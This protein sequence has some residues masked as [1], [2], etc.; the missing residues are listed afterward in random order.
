MKK[1]AIVATIVAVGIVALSGCGNKKQNL[2]KNNNAVAEITVYEASEENAAETTATVS[3]DRLEQIAKE[4][5]QESRREI[6]KGAEYTAYVDS[7]PDVPDFKK[8]EKTEIL[9][10][11]VA[12]PEYI[13]DT[14]ET[15]YLHFTNDNYLV[16]DGY[17]VRVINKGIESEKL[18]DVKMFKNYNGKLVIVGFS[19]I[20]DCRKSWKILLMDDGTIVSQEM[21][22]YNID[23]VFEEDS[24][25][26][27]LLEAAELT[28]VQDQDAETIE[29][30]RFN[31]VVYTASMP[32]KA[33]GS[34]ATFFLDNEHNLYTTLMSTS[35]DTPWVQLLKVDENVDKLSSEYF[36]EK[37]GY[38]FPIY[39]KEDAEYT[40]LIDE[41]TY[42]SYFYMVYP[43]GCDLTV[44]PSSHV[45]II[46]PEDYV[47]E[48]EEAEETE[49]TEIHAE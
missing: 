2:A 48:A 6:A 31:E 25:K 47:P 26:K 39:E 10:A 17:S 33:E 22:D 21:F 37:E 16:L 41:D 46:H 20:S 38:L 43:Y 44:E 12:A 8:D 49:E 4:I 1:M 5:E 36:Q 3:D 32:E 23:T 40:A 15:V 42:R 18:L 14:D 29:F 28:V 34:Y 24:T 30:Y 9:E 13:F 7:L 35:K 11:Y 27:I 19:A 45:E